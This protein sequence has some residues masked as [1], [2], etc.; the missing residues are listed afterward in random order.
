VNPIPATPTINAAGPTTFCTGGSVLLTSSAATGNQWYLNGSPIGGQTSQ[1]YI[2]TTAGTYTVVQTSN[3]CSSAPSAGTVVVINALPAAFTLSGTGNPCTGLAMSLSGSETGVNYQL[4]LNGSNTGA[5]VAGTGASI[6]LG[7]QTVSGTYTAVATNATTGCTSSM[8]GSVVL[9]SC[10]GIQI[11]GKITWENNPASGVKDATVNLT[12]PPND[13]KLTDVSGN[14][15]LMTNVPGSYTITPVKNINPLNG[16][17][18][19]D[20]TRI[21]QHIAGTNPLP[22]AFKRIAADVNGSNSITSVD[23]AILQQALLGNPNALA[24]MPKYWRFV[25]K[26]YTFPNPNTPWGFPETITL[27]NVTANVS[28]QDFTGIKIGDVDGT[29][30]PA[31]LPLEPMV[32]TADDQTLT[33]DEMIISLHASHVGD[34]AAFQFALHLNPQLIQIQEVEPVTSALNLTAGNVGTYNVSNGELRVLWTRPEGVDISNG[35]ELFR[36]H[37]K[38]LQANASKL[39]DV[40]YLDHNILPGKVYNEQLSEGPVQL[41]FQSVTAI[42]GAAGPDPSFQLLQNNPNPFTER[43]VIGFVLPEACEARLSFYDIQ[44]RMLQEIT[45][46]YPAGYNEEMLQLGRLQDVDGMLYYDLSTPF[47]K[48]TR[49]MIHIRY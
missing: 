15:T 6:S 48:L 3:G 44:G 37:V 10:A 46:K 41:T 20:V 21:Q 9:I 2:A 33:G 27:P 16:V 36:L 1:T 25:P 32:L 47:G 43:T 12:G 30:N 8:N 28:G 13:S 31:T 24:Q 17:S 4:K 19:A 35:A 29:A 45:K 23:A 39:S 5:P 42:H 11:S 14:Y 40:L 49:K 34:V 22:G 38:I 7:T 26:Y 18:A